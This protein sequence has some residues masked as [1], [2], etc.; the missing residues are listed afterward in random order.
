MSHPDP[1][2]EQ[3]FT[4]LS[5]SYAETRDAIEAIPDLGT[6]FAHMTTLDGLLQTW[7][8]AL[9]DDRSV[10]AFRIRH[11]NALSLTELG[12]FVKIS[13]TRAKQLYDR[14]KA[15]RPSERGE[16]ES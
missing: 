10:V 8:K 5:R 1:P 12:D 14:G 9:S 6:R 13:P 3:V 16:E 4:T 11:E 7:V 15:Q 2:A